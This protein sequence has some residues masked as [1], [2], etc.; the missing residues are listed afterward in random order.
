LY[1]F[2]FKFRFIYVLQDDDIF[3]LV[4]YLFILLYLDDKIPVCIVQNRISS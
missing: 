4:S 3:S 2:F 1:T